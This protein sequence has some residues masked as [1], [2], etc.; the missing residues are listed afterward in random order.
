MKNEASKRRLDGEQI[1]EFPS[2]DNEGNEISI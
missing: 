2:I 1:T